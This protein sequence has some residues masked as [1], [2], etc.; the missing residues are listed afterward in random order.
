MAVKELP[1]ERNI[2]PGLRTKAISFSQQWS[3]L[4]EDYPR[5]QLDFS[6]P[7]VTSVGLVLEGFLRENLSPPPP[8]F[9]NGA[10]AYIG[11]IGASLW[12]LSPEQGKKAAT[13][14]LSTTEGVVLTKVCQDTGQLLARTNLTT[15]LT[16]ICHNESNGPSEILTDRLTPF[17]R[18]R[19][20]CLEL[21][22]GLSPLIEGSWKEDAPELRYN[23][24][25]AFD[26]AISETTATY[27]KR[28]YPT[29]SELLNTAIFAGGPLSPPA[30]V[31][32][33]GLFTRSALA[34]HRNLEAAGLKDEQRKDILLDLSNAFDPQL[35]AAASLLF[36]AN[37]NP[38]EKQIRR[39]RRTM[40]YLAP[41]SPHL[42]PVLEV[43]RRGC[44]VAAT[45]DLI[46]QLISGNN[47]QVLANLRV[48]LD[49]ERSLLFF[50]CIP[51][52]LPKILSV[53]KLLP[54]I[55]LEN[56][57]AAAQLLLANISSFESDPYLSVLAAY[58]CHRSNNREGLDIALRILKTNH[59]SLEQETSLLSAWSLQ[60]K[61]DIIYAQ[62]DFELA[63]GYYSDAA[64]HCPDSDPQLLV[65]IYLAHGLC[66]MKMSITD[67]AERCFTEVLRIDPENQSALSYLSAIDYRL[68]PQA[69]LLRALPYSLSAVM[70]VMKDTKDRS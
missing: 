55:Y 31:N 40:Q 7:S 11:V 29:N 17:T 47:D 42:K 2:D 32:E 9:I 27:L 69:L 34:L 28:I 56:Y 19:K 58:C 25:A 54:L 52:Q 4:F 65:Q 53:T 3:L 39:L 10:T 61:G 23:R 38:D 50:P 59:R 22:S 63:A 16:S 67:E 12:Q 64:Q 13:K 33:P 45:I 41:L 49:T 43:L 44:K 48:R 37:Y 62:G 46:T 26:L 18:L 68:T 5:Y 14:L 35:A 15:A 60:L 66:L 36:T 24:A 21:F 8:D 70:S 51:L 20:L 30:G 57:E 6:W 1:S